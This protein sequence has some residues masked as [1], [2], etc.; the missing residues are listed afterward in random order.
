[1]ERWRNP[2]HERVTLTPAERRVVELLEQSL[3]P[4]RGTVA[5]ARAAVGHMPLRVSLLHQV[6]R[7]RLVARWLAP[8]GALLFVIA[9]PV[10]VAWSCAA[11]ALLGLGL[12]ACLAQLR[13]WSLRRSRT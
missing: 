6:W 5:D 9:L 8:L 4:A 11:V 13:A 3:D 1:M 2:P 10:S 7:A 12:A